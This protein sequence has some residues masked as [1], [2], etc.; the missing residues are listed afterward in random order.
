MGCNVSKTSAEVIE[1]KDFELAASNEPW[2]IGVPS[3][4]LH[5]LHAIKEEREEE[6]SV[7]SSTSNSTFDDPYDD[8]KS[9]IRQ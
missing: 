3:S 6:G 8:R 5:P 4:D 1:R 7:C 9:P 2:R